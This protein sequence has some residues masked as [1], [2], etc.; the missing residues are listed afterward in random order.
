MMAT[1]EYS[2]AGTMLQVKFEGSEQ[3]LRRYIRK[4]RFVSS[5][6]ILLEDNNTEETK[7]TYRQDWKQQWRKVAGMWSNYDSAQDDFRAIRESFNARIP[8]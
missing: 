3:E 7:S 5:R 8:Q 4:H 2:R 6:I 1:R